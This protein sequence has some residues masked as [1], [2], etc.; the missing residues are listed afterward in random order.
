M[1]EEKGTYTF[2]V[3]QHA[4]LVDLVRQLEK[5]DKSEKKRIRDKIRKIGLYWSMIAPGRDYTV[6]NLLRLFDIGTL[7]VI[8]VGQQKVQT[9]EQDISMTVNSKNEIH[10]NTSLVK[11]SRQSSDEHYVIDLCDEV[12]G[13]KASRQHR[14]DF[15]KGDT[16]VRLPVDAYYSELNLVIEYYESQ[17]TESTPFFDK[18]QTANGVSR[19]EQRRIYDQRRRDILPQH[20]IKLIIISYTDFGY[21]KKIKRE[22]MADKEIIKCILRKEGLIN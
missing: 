11:R 19:G 6:E 18:K 3:E 8:S 17:H 13:L 22:H 21:T 16:G 4:H 20:G 7:K 10:R 2:T 1:K 15:L 14:F 5:A 9:Q 12:L